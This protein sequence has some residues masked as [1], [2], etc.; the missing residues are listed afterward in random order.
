MPGH[1][2][3]FLSPSVFLVSAMCVFATPLSGLI[4]LA[5]WQRPDRTI[6]PAVSE[7]LRQ[8]EALAVAAKAARD[9]GYDLTDMEFRFNADNANWIE[10][11]W[12]KPSLLGS[13]VRTE[14]KKDQYWAFLFLCKVQ[15]NVKDGGCAAWVLV[16][17][18]DLEVLGLIRD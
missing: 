14:L 7:V 2:P 11:T 17:Q 18:S 12:A 10:R 5:S 4:V 1:S 16:R 13:P 15:P 8:N 3:T 6:Y 9:A